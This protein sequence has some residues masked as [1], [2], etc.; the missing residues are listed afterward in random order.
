MWREFQCLTL[1]GQERAAPRAA[2]ASPV[3]SGPAA[4]NHM[5]FNVDHFTLFGLPRLFRLDVTA[6]DARY[7]ELAAQV[8]PDRFAQAGDAERRL[9]LQWATRVNEAYQTLNS[10]LKRAQYLL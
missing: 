1:A 8:H 3:V 7:R 9:S 10:P 2:S 4:R 6:L 5:D